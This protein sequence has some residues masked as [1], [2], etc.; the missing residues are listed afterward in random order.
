[1]KDGD[2][3]LIKLGR[4]NLTIPQA[5]SCALMKQAKVDYCQRDCIDWQDFFEAN[6]N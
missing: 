6:K 3:L 1:M 5:V 4:A 2:K